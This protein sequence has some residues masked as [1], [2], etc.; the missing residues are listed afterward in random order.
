MEWLGPAGIIA[1]II[2]L[3]IAAYKG[4]NIIVIAPIAA[5]LMSALY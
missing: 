5:I 4:V 1:G 3:I 2:L